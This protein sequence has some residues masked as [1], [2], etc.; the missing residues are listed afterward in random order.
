[1]KFFILSAIISLNTL[2]AFAGNEQFKCSS[3]Y[4]AYAGKGKLELVGTM[5]NSSN[6]IQE[7]DLTFKSE[8][9]FS[10]GA[11]FADTRYNP[12]SS[13]YKGYN[14]FEIAYENVAR[15]F[16]D[17]QFKILIPKNFGEVEVFTAYLLTQESDGGNTVNMN[18]TVNR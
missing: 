5:S 1:M 3:N 15:A 7:L 6:E 18:C 16:N 17:S 10:A 14:R 11:I 4:F 12:R 2:S 13:T 8:V 9:V